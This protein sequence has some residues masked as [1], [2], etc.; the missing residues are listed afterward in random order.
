VDRAEY[1]FA[2]EAQKGNTFFVSEKKTAVKIGFVC[3]GRFEHLLLKKQLSPLLKKD[4]GLSMFFIT[5]N[6]I[7]RFLYRRRIYKEI[8][9]LCC[10]INA[11][12]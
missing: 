1:P 5:G 8:E 10:F 3:S 9:M 6:R 7:D 12:S 11:L 2:A 4:T